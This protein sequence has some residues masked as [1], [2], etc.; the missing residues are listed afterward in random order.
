MS[1]TIVLQFALN[2]KCMNYFY[3]SKVL[4]L[5]TVTKDRNLGYLN[6][7]VS[8]LKENC[9]LNSLS[10]NA[11]RIITLNQLFQL[12]QDDLLFYK[13]QL[14]FLTAL[15]VVKKVEKSKVTDQRKS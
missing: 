1:V 15:I 12:V 6:S 10:E 11:K 13:E 2:I 8:V 14:L 3:R 5:N 7:R 4:K 9:S